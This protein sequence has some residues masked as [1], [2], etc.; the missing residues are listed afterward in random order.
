LPVSE[1]I[2]L[3]EK[4][5]PIL[6]V[7]EQCA[8]LQLNRSNLYYQ[9]KPILSDTDISTM[10]KIDEIFTKRPYYGVPRI[11]K[12]L[13]KDI[14][15]A[16]HKRVYRLMGI[17]GIEAVFPKPNLSK[18]NIAHDIYPYLLTDLEV[19]HPNHVWGVDITYIRLRGDWLYLFVVLDWFSR[20]ILAWELSDSL[21]SDFCC[22]TLRRALTIAV[23]DIYNSD[24]GSQL[25]TEEY[26]EILKSH[27]EIKI[28]MDHKGRCFDNIFT[29]R[30]WRTIKY[31]EVY[32]KDYGSPREARQSLTEYLKFY[33]EERFHSSL[34]Y[35]TPAE[36]YFEKSVKSF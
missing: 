15:M 32:L 1:K 3:I 2:K 16:N 6:S 14:F 18:P 33:N 9:K 25:T 34:N 19:S 11:T 10:N 24:Q 7:R 5:N 27:S 13:N 8:L 35:K 31:E 20:Y 12:E 4:E 21:S 22:E 26:L 28:S 29:E 23:P 17:M 30:L 36:I